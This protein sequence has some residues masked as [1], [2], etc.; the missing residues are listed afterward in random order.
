MGVVDLVGGR[1]EGRSSQEVSRDGRR[2]GKADMKCLRAEDGFKLPS[3][4]LP[5]PKQ[6]QQGYHLNTVAVTGRK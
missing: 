3:S 1:S 6:Q 4:F 2:C 5:A